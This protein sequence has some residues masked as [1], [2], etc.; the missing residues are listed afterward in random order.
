VPSA[1]SPKSCFSTI[2]CPVEVALDFRLVEACPTGGFKKWQTFGF[3]GLAERVTTLPSEPL[4]ETRDL[5]RCWQTLN[6]N[7]ALRYTLGGYSPSGRGGALFGG[8]LATLAME[9]KKTTKRFDRTNETA[10]GALWSHGAPRFRRGS[11]S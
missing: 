7:L 4:G 5:E 3:Y 11:R 2:R 10:S 8:L 6:A 9:M 1:N